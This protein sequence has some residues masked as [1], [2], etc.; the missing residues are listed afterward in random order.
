MV[1]G[2]GGNCFLIMAEISDTIRRCTFVY[3]SG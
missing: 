2:G 1:E 3:V